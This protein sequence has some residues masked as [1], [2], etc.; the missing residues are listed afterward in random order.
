MRKLLLL[1]SALLLTGGTL[2]ALAACTTPAVTAS[3]GGVSSFTVNT[4][5]ATV[6]Q[7]ISVN[8]GSGVLALLS[9]DSIKLQLTSATAVA[10]T[11]SR[12]ALK[13]GSDL[14]PVQLCTDSACTNELAIGGTIYTM[15]RSQL[16]G[17]NIGGAGQVIF[18]VP[19]YLRTMAGAVVAEGNYT[20][21]LTVT[22]NYDVCTGIGLL[23][24]CLLGSQQTGSSAQLITVNMAIS[25]DCTTITA[26]V[27]N[28]GS[29]PLVTSF[30]A[31]SQSINVICT[32]GSTYTVGL[33]N[34][35]HAVG[36]QR[37]MTSSAGGQLAYEIYKGSGTTRWGSSVAAERMA[38][39]AANTTSTDGL[40]RTFN[41]NAQVLTSQ[42]TPAAGAYSDMVTV[43]LSF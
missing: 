6:Q 15:T 16:L 20:V 2:P 30:T 40:T 39:S 22:V 25:K 9:S 13:Q 42:A 28:F 5:P 1:F 29:A 32:K 19:L 31:V 26:P 35:Q 43:D 7:N 10:T 34:G 37:Y 3:F 33:N 11:G 17:L 21:T 27:V 4:T 36:T 8:C 14:I 24:A 23:G 41:Y 12:G 18:N 38:S